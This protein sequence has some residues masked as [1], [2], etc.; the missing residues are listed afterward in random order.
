MGFSD[1]IRGNVLADGTS[2]GIH[3]SQSRM[4]ENMIGRS[5]SFWKRYLPELR[6][7]FPES[8]GAAELR[9]FY[10]AV[11]RVEPSLVRVEADE[12]T[13]NL[14]IIVRF[15]LELALMEG[16]LTVDAL[17]SAWNDKYRELLGVAPRTDAEGLLQD[18]HWS[19]GAFGYFP[20]Y[21][22]G[23]MY[24]A[25]FFAALRRDVSDVS[26][27][28]AAGRFSPILTWLRENIHRHGSALTAEELCRRIT[29]EA[30]NPD[31]FLS[32]VKEKTRTVYEL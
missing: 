19:H 24:A 22:L 15:E 28:I 25:Q 30:L 14:H 4:W 10:R 5:L 21:S 29:G 26:G 23:N 16:R 17:P 18:V 6:E 32:Y 12:V 31:F 11:N 20:T 1:E 27:G 9:A 7:Q 2:L 8:L 13:Y 3:E